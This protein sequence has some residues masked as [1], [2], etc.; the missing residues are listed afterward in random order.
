MGNVRHAFRIL[1]RESEEKRLVG[2]VG[3]DRRMV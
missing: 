2:G 3:I 1:V